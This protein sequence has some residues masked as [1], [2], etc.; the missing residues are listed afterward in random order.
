MTSNSPS[1][2][3]H[4]VLKPMRILHTCYNHAWHKTN[5]NLATALLH[6]IGGVGRKNIL[7]L[8]G[9]TTILFDSN[10]WIWYQYCLWSWIPHKIYTCIC[11]MYLYLYVFSVSWKTVIEGLKMLPEAAGLRQHFQARGHSFSLYGP[12]LRQITCLTFFSCSKLVLQITQ[13]GLFTQLCHWIGL[14]ALC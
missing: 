13:M 8:G 10:R 11:D 12:T 6:F 1:N 4:C 3:T 9:V 2:K 14:C 7:M 5:C